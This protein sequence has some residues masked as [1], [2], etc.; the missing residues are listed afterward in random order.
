[1][2]SIGFL[3]VDDYGRAI[4]PLHAAAAT[5]REQPLDRVDPRGAYAA[6]ALLLEHLGEPESART[7]AHAV[8]SLES[9]RGRP[10][11]CAR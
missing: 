10:S 3:P 6:I 8:R 7:L 5:R 9:D 11:S 2:R 1:V 4:E